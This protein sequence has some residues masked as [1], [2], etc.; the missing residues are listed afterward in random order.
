MSKSLPHPIDQVPE[1]V[2]KL[3]AIVS[4][5]QKL[6]PGRSFTPDG[7]LVGSIG[8][9]LAASRYSLVLLPSSNAGHDAKT[10]D[11]RQV[12]L[13]ATQGSRVALRSE[14]EHLI[15]LHLATDGTATEVF[16]GPG[17]LV[18]SECGKMQK[19]GQR[20]ISVSKLRKLMN[21][22]PISQR[23]ETKP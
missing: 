1:L 20:S 11:G 21:D 8:E 4:E 23:I 14:P 10:L 2:R 9:V 22:V 3:Y 16:N 18:W 6:F 17:F 12:E 19:N 5:F 15:V 13:K 7:H